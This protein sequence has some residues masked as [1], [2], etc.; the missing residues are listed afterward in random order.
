MKLLSLN[1]VLRLHQQLLQA[2]GGTS[3]VRDMGLLESALA[4]PFATFGGEYLYPTLIQ[5]AAQLGYGII[6][7]HPFADGN[8]RTGAHTMLVFL[9][10]NGIELEY[11]QQELIDAI[12]AVAD[13]TMAADQLAVW[14]TK[15]QC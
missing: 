7:N 11:D 13:G 12:L 8:M 2:F 5:Q 9:S 1:M 3:G 15:H 4:A 14:L 10:V 6:R